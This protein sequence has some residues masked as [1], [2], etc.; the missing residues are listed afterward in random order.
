MGADSFFFSS[1]IIVRYGSKIC[2][3]CRAVNVLTSI[4]GRPRKLMKS[5]STYRRKAR[6]GVNIADL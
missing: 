6:E 1:L 2:S 3:A 5:R 4:E